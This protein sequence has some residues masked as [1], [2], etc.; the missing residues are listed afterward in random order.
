[1]DPTKYTGDF[2]GDGLTDYLDI[3]ANLDVYVYTNDGDGT[4]SS[5]SAYSIDNGNTFIGAVIADYNGDG[6]EDIASISID[7]CTWERPGHGTESCEDYVFTF[8]ENNNGNFTAKKSF[9]TTECICDDV[10][11][12]GSPDLDDDFDYKIIPG[13]FN[14]D[15]YND[16][17]IYDNLYLG[18]SDM[19]NI[20]EIQNIGYEN[21][22]YAIDFNGDG[23]TEL[24]T[25]ETNT[26]NVKEYDGTTLSVI[27]SEH[28]LYADGES[29]FFGDFNGDG[30]SDILLYNN[31]NNDWWIRYGTGKGFSA[32]LDAPI[33][34][35]VNPSL[36]T[37]DYLYYVA[38][39]DGNGKDDILEL[40]TPSNK[41]IKVYYSNGN[42]QFS[43]D[44]NDI[45]STAFDKNKISLGNLTRDGQI[46]IVLKTNGD[47]YSFYPYN[48]SNKIKSIMDGSGIMTEINYGRITDNNEDFYNQD[49]ALTFPLNVYTIPYTIV[50]SYT[51]KS[52]LN[53]DVTF[54]NV[55]FKYE[56]AILHKQG[57]GFL[58]FKKVTRTNT[59]GNKSI[60][61]YNHD[62]PNNSPYLAN[63]KSYFENKL[64]SDKTVV[65]NYNDY[66]LSGGTN[67]FVYQDQIT[68]VDELNNN[69]T[70]IDNTYDLNSNLTNQKKTFADGSYN[71]IVPTNYKG[72]GSY[73]PQQIT[74]NNKHKD[75]ANVFSSISKFS[76]G[77]NDNLV[78]VIK[79]FGKSNQITIQYTETEIND[80]GIA[81]EIIETPSGL[82]AQTKTLV[83]ESTGRFPT[84]S[85]IAS[86]GTETFGYDELG[87]VLTAVDIYG[88]R[89]TNA[90]NGW[91]NLINT[92]DQFDNSVSFNLEWGTLSDPVGTIFKS[93]KT[94]LNSPSATEYI[95]FAGRVVRTKSEG[96]SGINYYVDREFNNRNLIERQTNGIA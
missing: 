45:G 32:Y 65:M 38:D 59:N 36:S 92:T 6:L 26:I 82:N 87:N 67:Y 48:Y 28:Y 84:S 41:H 25:F 56:N 71:E 89:I 93:E 16:V 3:D 81:E 19:Q 68:I 1:M 90:Y 18:S 11:L 13:D 70:T 83:F 37:T 31:N 46:D 75:D 88:N 49:L 2:N 54:S 22:N 15:G 58:G 8:Y 77:T 12:V 63:R 24:V 5:S 62:L 85:T 52:T 35:T 17:I 57:F 91:G 76:Y 79:N 20:S 43:A 78:Q 29:I 14:G 34:S 7:R 39:V 60:H 21:Y 23:K 94:S 9:S 64:L 53:T 80:F 69:T 47:I 42:N 51:Q 4:F 86:L 73:K 95:D 50:T 33:T 74:V 44:D 30:I 40:Y 61:T 55:S 10:T 96:F 66:T 72:N 27:Y